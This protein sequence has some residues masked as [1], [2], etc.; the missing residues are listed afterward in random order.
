VKPHE[1]SSPIPKKVN[2]SEVVD[3]E[4]EQRVISWHWRSSRNLSVF[5]FK[6]KRLKSYIYIERAHLEL[7]EGAQS[8]LDLIG[9]I[10][11]SISSNT[12]MSPSKPK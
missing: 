11:A 5:C 2:G 3:V 12:R 9:N 7:A 1:Q 4:I 6:T 8:S 10:S